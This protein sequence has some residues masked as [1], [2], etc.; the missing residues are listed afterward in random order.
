MFILVVFIF[1]MILVNLSIVYSS[2]INFIWV[3]NSLLVI[4]F[5]FSISYLSILFYFMLIYCMFV[6]L[7]FSRHYYGWSDNSLNLLICL[8]LLVM[9]ILVLTNDLILSL[10]FWE[11]LG[12]VSFIL[13]LYYSNYDTLFAANS[14]L[15]SSR[16]GD[17]GLFF[18][19]ACILSY[20]SLSGIYYIILLFLIVSTKSAI[21][22]ISSWLLEAMRAPTP[23]SSLVHSSTLVTAGVWFFINYSSS[24]LLILGDVLIYFSLISILLS[25]IGAICYNDIKK[26]IALSTCNNVSWCFIYYLFGFEFLCLIQLVT[27][28]IAKC[29]LFICIGDMLSFSYGSQNY[30]SVSNV[31]NNSKFNWLVNC[32]LSLLVCG[33]PMNGVYFSKHLLLTNF[34]FNS[35]IFLL[36]LIFLGI[37]FSYWYSGRLI[38][39]LSYNSLSL[40]SSL[41]NVFYLI[42]LVVVLSSLINFIFIN[43]SI[44]LNSLSLIFSWLVILIQVVGLLIGWFSQGYIVGSSFISLFYGQDVILRWFSLVYGALLKFYNILVSF[45]LEVYF[46]G[47]LILFN[48]NILKNLQFLGDNLIL[49][50][51]LFFFVS[52]FSFF[53]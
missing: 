1:L 51:V 52:L 45:R 25:A 46:V 7:N 43:A 32:I 27:H 44:E 49:F 17:V 30:K 28:G 21:Y 50:L 42:G 39:L 6:S 20:S 11:Y 40:N 4:N 19:I 38:Y 36:I 47:E 29:S 8:F 24:L 15:I 31:L 9:F 10:V 53:L 48:S 33:I 2:N 12:F 34:I 35:N 41:N 14:T 22:P 37:F 16:F 13:I 18:F 26:I 23:V 3:N 5:N